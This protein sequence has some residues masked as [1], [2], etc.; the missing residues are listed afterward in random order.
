M[1]Q[2]SRE[3]TFLLLTCRPY[4]SGADDQRLMRIV[5]EEPDWSFIL[6]RAESYQTLPVCLHHL[7][8]LDLGYAVPQ[9]VIA[10]MTAW[11]QLSRAR[12]E[13]QFKQ[14]GELL[15]HFRGADIDHYLFK[16]PMMSAL[17]YPDPALRPMQDIDLMVRAADVRRVQ[18]EL[19]ALGYQH[20]VFNPA[21]GVFT[22]MFRKI[23]PKT[24]EHKYALHSV[25]K[26]EEIRPALDVSLIAPEWRMRQIKSFVKDDGTVR[27][28]VFID[29]HFSLGEGMDEA[30]VW[31]GTGRRRVLG[32]E[33]P[34]QS[35]TT[36]LWF[37][38]ARVYYEAFQHG[39]LKL[40]MLGDIDALLRMHGSE[41]DW[42]QLLAIASKYRFSAAIFYVLEQVRRLFDAPIPMQVLVLLLP[43][44][45]RQP[46]PADFGDILPKLLSRTV[47]TDI[48]LA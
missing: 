7:R 31:R 47:V 46:D 11:S 17:L 30:D 15:A 38:A 40:Q 32:R 24:M 28:P 3:E 20:G 12:S 35:L 34:S 36:A 25:T 42:P 14:L 4:L 21:D 6:W 1:V 39:T 13:V 45:T 16:G 44:P 19:Y 10:Y 22:H 43:D 8:R 29:V 37:S 33:V 9:W 18:R 27:M 48:E 26:V 2:L 23:T 41:I 5:A